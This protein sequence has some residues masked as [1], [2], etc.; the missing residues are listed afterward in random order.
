MTNK[1]PQQ[2]EAIESQPA[3]VE[4]TRKNPGTPPTDIEALKPGDKLA[5][6]LYVRE[7]HHIEFFEKQHRNGKGGMPTEYTDTDIT[8]Q[9]SERAIKV[10][11]GIERKTL[12]FEKL[13]ILTGRIVRKFQ[14]LKL[15]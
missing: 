11:I 14:D 3:I 2:P 6:Y 15:V 9:K 10:T 4:S 12:T 7:G 5:G 8:I 13:M 1:T